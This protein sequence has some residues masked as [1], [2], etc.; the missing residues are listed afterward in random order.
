MKQDGVLS[1]ILFA[2]YIDIFSEKMN[3]SQVGCHIGQKFTGGYGYADDVIL[4]VPTKRS[5]Y[6]LLD[7]C[8]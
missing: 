1:P 4:I 6:A 7:I 8:T 3:N 5:V 2:V